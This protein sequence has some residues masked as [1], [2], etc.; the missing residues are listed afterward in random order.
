[1]IQF[2][3]FL[4]L[5]FCFIQ[6]SISAQSEEQIVINYRK[7]L[8]KA[9][10]GDDV[11]SM[12]INGDFKIENINLPVKILFKAP[13][14]LKLEMTL[15]GFKF[16]HIAN[17]SMTWD[18]NALENKSTIVKVDK[19]GGGM[20][21]Q[22]S[23]FDYISYDLLNYKDSA[24]Y[25]LSFLNKQRI[26]SVDANVLELVKRGKKATFYINQRTNLLYRIND[27]KGYR[28]FANYLNESGYVF[29]RFILEANSKQTIE[30]NFKQ[31][32][33]NVAIADSVFLIPKKAIESKSA[34]EKSI[35]VMF[36]KADEHYNQKRYDSASVYYSKILE[37]KPRS[38]RAY[39]S[40]G[41]SR[42]EL[43]DYY[44]AIA[45]FTKAVEIDPKGANAINNKG[46]AKYYLGDKKGALKEYADA[47]KVDSALIVAYKNR[48]L[49]YMQD[50]QYDLAL[51]NY[52]I[53]LRFAPQD[54]SV[55]YRYGLALAQ[56]EKY[57]E[58]RQSYQKAVD[59]NFSSHEFFNH[60]GVAEYKLNDLEVAKNSFYQA[61]VLE[62]DN[63]QY[64]ENYGRT[65][66]EMGD[67]GPASFQFDTYLKKDNTNAEII[68]LKGLCKYQ[69]KN[70]KGAIKDFTQAISLKENA[71]YFDNRASAKEALE[72]FRGAVEDYN[73]SIRLY[74][75]DAS[76]FYKRG[77]LKIK[78][79]KNEEGCRDLSTANEMKYEAAK[80]AI[81]KNCK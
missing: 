58:A 73:E 64:L 5:A 79:K 32:I 4:L 53:A 50:E 26:D 9:I 29:P 68:N 55:H 36:A 40:R 44:E 51:T 74:P 20:P 49:I 48:G 46:L 33:L 2:R 37:K 31:L 61:L 47:L 78:I 30:G 27:H 77:L 25:K 41:L 22:G 45:D 81:K 14:L 39:N 12:E 3:N 71:T 69:E 43:Q 18:Y 17:D 6:I 60:K 1:M 52:S 59:N 70:F 56:L 62:P 80:D 65:L 42:I 63:L 76:V 72:D 16:L 11:K 8:Q 19:K 15:M 57:Q 34:E 38:Y 7:A 66:Y 10:G 54:G 67:Y 75:T 24:S 28:I 21:D 23:T 13:N 35:E